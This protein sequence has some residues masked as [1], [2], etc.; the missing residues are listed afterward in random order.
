MVR[1]LFCFSSR[2]RFLCRRQTEWTSPG[3]SWLIQSSS[4][5]TTAWWRRY[6][7]E[8]WRLTPSSACWLC[9][10]P[11]WPR[12]RRRVS[13]HQWT[14]FQQVSFCDGVNF[15]VFTSSQGSSSI[16][17]SLLMRALWS[18]RR[19][20]SALCSAHERQRASRSWRWEG[21]SPMIFWLFLTLIMFAR[22]CPS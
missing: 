12:R 17:L 1:S 3:T 11:S 9:A 19:A 10:T 6:E 13:V 14:L 5:M 2:L 22:E 15:S 20:T 18:L 4:S 7:K 16:R 8:T 21:K